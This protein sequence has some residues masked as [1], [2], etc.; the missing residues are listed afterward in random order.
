MNNEIVTCPK[1]GEKMKKVLFA[2]QKAFGIFLSADLLICFGIL[3]LVLVPVAGLICGA[4]LI[5]V[6]AWLLYKIQKGWKCKTCQRIITEF[7]VI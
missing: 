2:N 6:G 5:V 7:E 1:C 3:L 4:I